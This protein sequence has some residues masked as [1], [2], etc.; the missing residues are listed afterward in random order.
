M[1][2]RQ[3]VDPRMH[4]KFLG[5]DDDNV[6]ITS[7]NLLSAD[8]SSDFAEL[9]IHLRASGIGRRLREKLFLTFNA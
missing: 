7:H 3:I 1:Q 9:G 8:P 6:V 4:A 2:I 5:W